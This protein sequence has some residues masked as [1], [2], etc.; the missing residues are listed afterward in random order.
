MNGED[1]DIEFAPSVAY[2]VYWDHNHNVI[3]DTVMY[4]ETLYPI[5]LTRAIRIFK[6]E[7]AIGANVNF[8]S[9]DGKL[10]DT[11]VFKL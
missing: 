3:Q 2:I 8:E 4:A 5:P 10:T 1:F 9:V 7:F 6:P 11:I